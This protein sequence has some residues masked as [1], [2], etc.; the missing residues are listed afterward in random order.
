[1]R[2]ADSTEKEGMCRRV[3]LTVSGLLRNYGPCR[4]NRKRARATDMTPNVEDNWPADEMPTEGYVAAVRFTV[5][6][7]RH[8]IPPVVSAHSPDNA[9]CSKKNRLWD[10][11]SKCLRGPQIDTQFETRGMFERHVSGAFAL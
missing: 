4:L 10:V 3:R 11:D 9:L 8:D 6:F 5:R 2:R 7:G 1:M